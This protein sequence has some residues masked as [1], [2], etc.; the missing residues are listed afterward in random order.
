MSNHR[1]A[2]DPGPSLASIWG[3]AVATLVTIA[4]SVWII[5]GVPIDERHVMGM[6]LGMLLATLLAAQTIVRSLDRETARA[7]QERHRARRVAGDNPAE[8]VEAR[9]PEPAERG[10]RH[11]LF[12]EAPHRGA[13]LEMPD[14]EP[15]PVATQ[16]WPEPIDQP[17]PWQDRE[18]TQ[19]L[20]PPQ[21][22]SPA[23]LRA[24]DVPVFRT[25]ADRQAF[26]DRQD[27]EIFTRP[28]DWQS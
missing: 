1:Q 23:A 8:A 20:T 26:L 28:P 14:G 6:V 27:T 24:I 18:P 22:P 4:L 11:M 15:D 17:G 9:W 7:R 13:H 21:P 19:R 25:E 12:R 3:G 5:W 16:P 2:T 10:H